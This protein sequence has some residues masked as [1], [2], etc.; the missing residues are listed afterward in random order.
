MVRTLALPKSRTAQS[1][2]P[3]GHLLPE[4]LEAI[5]AALSHRHR[6]RQMFVDTSREKVV[7]KIRVKT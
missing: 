4:H 7:N 2:T 3:V 6:I 1:S 5:R